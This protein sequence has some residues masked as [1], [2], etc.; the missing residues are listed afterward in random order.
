MVNLFCLEKEEKACVYYSFKAYALLYRG[1][2]VR[3]SVCG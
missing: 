3:G 2:I 1:L